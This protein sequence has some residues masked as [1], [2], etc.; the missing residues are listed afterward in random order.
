MTKFL[1]GFLM[2]FIVLAVIGVIL[3][4]SQDKKIK[5]LEFKALAQPKTEIQ[6]LPGESIEIEKPIPPT[7]MP[8]DS[9]KIYHE[10]WEKEFPAVV[11]ERIRTDTLWLHSEEIAGADLDTTFEDSSRIYIRYWLPPISYFDVKW[12]PMTRHEKVTTISMKRESPWDFAATL[13]TGKMGENQYH[14]GM[15]GALYFKQI[16]AAAYFDS[17]GLYMFGLSKIW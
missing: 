8:R 12:Y 5:D 3:L 2:T 10:K 17:Q 14:I 4:V 13:L 1:T 16:G 9:L 15:T 6:Y 11:I 7:Y